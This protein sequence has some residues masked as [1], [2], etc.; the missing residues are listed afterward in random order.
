MPSLSFALSE[1]DLAAHGRGVAVMTGQAVAGC[2]VGGGQQ[3][4][5]V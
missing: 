5:R 2:E 3:G 1:A 4:Y